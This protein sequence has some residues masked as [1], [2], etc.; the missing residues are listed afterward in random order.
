MLDR[1]TLEKRRA[2]HRSTKPPGVHGQCA[3]CMIPGWP[4]DRYEELTLAME[5]ERLRARLSDAER[6]LE[7]AGRWA[8]QA[9][10]LCA[11]IVGMADAYKSYSARAGTETAG[12]ETRLSAST[13]A[14]VEMPTTFP[15]ASPRAH[16]CNDDCRAD[17]WHCATCGYPSSAYGHADCKPLGAGTEAKG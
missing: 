8:N 15:P 7:D 5:A 16:E 13:E 6:N 14:G 4:C 9:R 17:R 10:N 3:H 12:R 1:E 2:Q 11:S